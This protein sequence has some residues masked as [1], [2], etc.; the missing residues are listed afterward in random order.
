MMRH[1][2][3][4]KDLLNEINNDI[5]NF[6]NGDISAIEKDIL[7][8][9]IKYLYRVTADIN[10]SEKSNKT[11]E[12]EDAVNGTANSN[13]E[14]VKDISNKTEISEKKTTSIENE[15]K[16][17]DKQKSKGNTKDKDVDK[18]EQKPD[19]KEN[20]D[21]QKIAKEE[22]K[23][24]ETNIK[25]PIQKILGEELQKD[26]TSLNE[27]F[28]RGND[29]SDSIVLTPLSDIKAG[30]GLG[31]RFLYIRELFDGSNDKFEDTINKLNKMQSIDEAVSFLKANFDWDI[32]SLTVKTFLNVVKRKFI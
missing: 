21:P 17:N 26:R 28:T 13:S 19:T 25:K 16:N 11:I 20:E 6:E 10:L 32:S 5:S 7:L 24:E 14:T 9:K 1:I 27:L 4:I 22:E 12:S 15:S 3:S 18:P 23:S 2:N 30:I 8:D 29:V 31:D